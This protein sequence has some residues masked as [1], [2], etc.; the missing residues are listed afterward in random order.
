MISDRVRKAGEIIDELR[1]MSVTGE[2]SDAADLG[3]AWTTVA[4][5]KNRT[6]VQP[7]HLDVAPASEVLR[8]AADRRSATRLAGS[9]PEAESA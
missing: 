7:A 1:E 4:G 8:R 2:E 3:L 5:R 6:L 9:S